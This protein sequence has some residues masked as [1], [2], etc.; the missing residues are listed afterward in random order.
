MSWFY[1]MIAGLFELGWVIGIKYCE[2]F[3]LNFALCFVALSMIGSV[4]FLWLAIKT[5]PMSIAYAVWT[6]I[7]IVGAFCYGVLVLK[8]ELSALNLVCVGLIL[9]GI[10]GLK[11]G[12]K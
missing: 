3:K 8:E 9:T 12:M 6:G 10:I 2:S 5:I 7:G 4:V 11:L 1:L